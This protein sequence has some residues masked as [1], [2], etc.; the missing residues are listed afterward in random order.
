MMYGQEN[1]KLCR[2][3]ILWTSNTED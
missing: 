3:Q 2:I 1:I